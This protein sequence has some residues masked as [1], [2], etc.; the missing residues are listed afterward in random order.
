[1]YST[2]LYWPAHCSVADPERGWGM[3]PPPAWDLAPTMHRKWPFWGPNWKKNSGERAQPL[4]RPLLLAA[5]RHSTT[6]PHERFLDPPLSLLT[7]LQVFTCWCA[8]QIYEWM[9]VFIS[10]RSETD[11]KPVIDTRQLKKIT[12]ELKQ[13]AERYVTAYEYKYSYVVDTESVT[14]KVVRLKSNGQSGIPCKFSYLNLYAFIICC[15]L[16]EKSNNLRERGHTH[17]TY[18]VVHKL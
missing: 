6:S 11:W 2:T 3:H 10:V 1:M 12:E 9:K 16:K 8:V 13:N 4:P 17:Q 7:A 14:V 18:L 5:Y 15:H